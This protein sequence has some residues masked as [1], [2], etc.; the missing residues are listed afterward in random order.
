MRWAIGDGE[1]CILRDSEH[2]GWHAPSNGLFTPQRLQQAVSGSTPAGR[3]A[4]GMSASMAGGVV[5]NSAP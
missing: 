1:A 3:M 5:A 4:L 2:D